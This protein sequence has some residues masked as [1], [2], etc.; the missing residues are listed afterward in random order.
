MKSLSKGTQY[1]SNIPWGALVAA[2]VVS[3]G[4]LGIADTFFPVRPPQGLIGYGCEGS[5]DGEPLYAREE[6]EFPGKC[7]EI[8]RRP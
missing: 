6:D 5:L 4:L 1:R 2:F 7:Q 3:A 8:V